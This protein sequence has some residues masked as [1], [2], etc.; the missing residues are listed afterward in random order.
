MAPAAEPLDWPEAGATSFALD[1][2]GGAAGEEGVAEEEGVRAE[3]EEEARSARVRRYFGSV[4]PATARTTSTVT[5]PR[6]I[7]KPR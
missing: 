6:V 5:A 1:A 4:R 7:Y 2:I 3:G